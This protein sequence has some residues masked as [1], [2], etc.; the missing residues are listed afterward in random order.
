MTILSSHRTLKSRVTQPVAVHRGSTDPVE[1]N[2]KAS[3]DE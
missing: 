3:V 2:S 1:D